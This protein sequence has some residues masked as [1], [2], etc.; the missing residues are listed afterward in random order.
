MNRRMMNHDTRAPTAGQTHTRR[1][2]LTRI[3]G[4]L[5]CCAAAI[6]LTTGPRPVRAAAST[7]PLA[8][9]NPPELMLLAASS[10]TDALGDIARSYTASTGQSVKLSFAASSA[11]AKQ[12]EAGAPADVFFSADTDWM[13]YLQQR[14]L[15]ATAT[16]INAV[17]NRLVLIAP[18]DSTVKL[19]IGPRFALAAALGDSGKLATGNPD[20]VPVGRYAKAAL[21]RLQVWEQVQD[22][23]VPA[24]N[25]RSALAFVARGEAPLG[26]VYG[27]DA[28]VEKGVRIVAE[29]PAGSH[30]PILYPVAATAGAREGAARF[31]KYMQ[32]RTAQAIFHK[33]GFGPAPQARP[34]P[35]HG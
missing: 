3:T 25:V 4:L 27:T 35:G 16:R 22:R 14:G 10:L 20:S 19:D 31:V 18:A 5:L 11:L 33:Y 28:L 15:I 30:E 29:F 7:A 9:K 13:D 12:I 26:I 21:T 17:A 32:S 23:I 8:E 6:V 2:L 1:A 34:W 24:D